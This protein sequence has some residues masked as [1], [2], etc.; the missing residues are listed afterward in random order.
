[1]NFPLHIT[2]MLGQGFRP[3][4][5]WWRR[6]TE[7]SGDDR[8]WVYSVLMSLCSE[9]GSKETFMAVSPCLGAKSFPELH[10]GGGCTDPEPHSPTQQGPRP[11]EQLRTQPATSALPS[12]CGALR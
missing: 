12:R 3:L 4:H 5:W 10:S 11:A 7:M 9:A 6:S 8:N 2:A 1:M